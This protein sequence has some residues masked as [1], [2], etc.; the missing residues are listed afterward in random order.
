SWLL[1]KYL[2]APINKIK[3]R[4]E[5]L[6]SEWRNSSYTIRQNALSKLLQIQGFNP[7]LQ[8]EKLRR[9]GVQFDFTKP[10]QLVFMRIDRYD[11][12]KT[13]GHRDI[14]TYKFAIMNISTEICSKHFHVD[15]LDLEADCLLMF[16]NIP[17]QTTIPSETLPLIMKEVQVACEEYLRLGITIAVTPLSSDPHQLFTLYKQAKEASLLRFFKGR[18][19]IIDVQ[20]QPL[21]QKAHT[22]PID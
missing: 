16:L 8:L 4:M 5:D 13:Q 1:S 19:A 7:K 2:Y 20:Q 21:A 22:F 12:L 14:L 15:A 17:E 11:E 9:I 18:G 10:Y 6:E 3:V